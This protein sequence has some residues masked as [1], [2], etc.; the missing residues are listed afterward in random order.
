MAIVS[1]RIFFIVR[2]DFIFLLSGLYQ[3]AYIG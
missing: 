2:S 3:C 1:N